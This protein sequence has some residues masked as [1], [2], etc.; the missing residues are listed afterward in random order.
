MILFLQEMMTLTFD[1]AESGGIKRNSFKFMWLC[2]WDWRKFSQDESTGKVCQCGVQICKIIMSVECDGQLLFI[3]YKYIN[4][5]WVRL[6]P[7][8]DLY[9]VFISQPLKTEDDLKHVMAKVVVAQWPEADISYWDVQPSFDDVMY[10]LMYCPYIRTLTDMRYT[11]YIIQDHRKNS[12]GGKISVLCDEGYAIIP[13]IV[14]DATCEEEYYLHINRVK[15]QY[16]SFMDR[17]RRAVY[18][19]R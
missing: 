7:V 15:I 6:N 5:V 4:N 8:R 2:G 10:R 16:N 9:K 13:Y 19:F 3:P 11:Y 12:R 1:V 17:L 14:G 18:R